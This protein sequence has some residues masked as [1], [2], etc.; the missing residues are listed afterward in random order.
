[1]DMIQKYLSVYDIIL[2]HIRAE[3]TAADAATTPEEAQKHSQL[4]NVYQNLFD[5]L[6]ERLEGI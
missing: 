2:G 3:A 6:F 5:E 1:M 4:E